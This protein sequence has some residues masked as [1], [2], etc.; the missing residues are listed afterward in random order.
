V[1]ST[2]ADL[3]WATGSDEDDVRYLIAEHL[4]IDLHDDEVPPELIEEV[5]GI[6]DPHN[7]RS[8]PGWYGYTGEDI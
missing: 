1:S 2:I 3:A 8:V 5:A 6:L 7:E 4:G